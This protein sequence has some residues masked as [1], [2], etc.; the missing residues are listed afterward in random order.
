MSEISTDLIAR[1]I[2]EAQWALA[3]AEKASEDL[4]RGMRVNGISQLT[5]AILIQ[6]AEDKL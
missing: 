1:A 6:C 3:G 2:D 4:L 5:M